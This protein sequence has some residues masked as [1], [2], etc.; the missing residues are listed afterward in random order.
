MKV[1][2]RSA[3]AMSSSPLCAVTSRPSRVNGT[4]SADPSC[5]GPW[6]AV[7]SPIGA[8]ALL[9][10]DEEL[11]AEHLDGRADGGGDGRPEH[12]DGGLLGRPGQSGGDVVARIEEQVEVLFAAV[13]RLDALHDL[14]QPPRALPAGRAL[15]A[16]LARDC[17]LYTSD[18]A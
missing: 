17:L 13:S 3:A 11:V 7:C 10:V 6:A 15:A 1:P 2:A 18:A 14:V 5:P 16:G 12:A 8:P 9:D 4:V